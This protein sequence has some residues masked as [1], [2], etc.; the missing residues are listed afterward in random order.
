MSDFI[1]QASHG[2]GLLMAWH[3]INWAKCR[4]I[5]RSLQRRIVEAVRAGL[6]RKAKRLSHILARSFSARA[7]AVKRVTENSGK[8]TA[9]VDGEIWNTPGK[10][11]GA[12]E[13]IGNWKSYRPKPSKRIYIPKKN[14]KKRPLSIPTMEDRARQALYK[15]ALEPIAETQADSNSYGFRAKRCCAD[16]IDQCFKVFRQKNSAEWILEADIKGFF[17]H[18]SFEWM[19]NHI[20]MN[21]KILGK[22]LKCG[23]VEKKCLFPTE[24]GVPQGG[25]I[26]PVLSNMVLDGLE[27]IVTHSPMFKRKYKINFIRYAD[28][29]NVS[30]SSK[31]I[32]EEAIIPRI[33]AFLGKRGVELSREKSEIT[34]INEGFDFLGQTIRK[35][36]MDQAN[37]GKL[38]IT[39]SQ[40][41]MKAIKAKIKEICKSSG[42]LTARELIDRLNP[43]LRGWANY[44]RHA[45]C[46]ESFGKIDNYVWIRLY[47]WA[48]KRHA[49]KTGTWIYRK[50]YRSQNGWR[51]C[52]TDKKSGKSVIR[53]AQR[54]KTQP[55]IKIRGDANPFDAKWENY[56][57]ERDW[58]L[59]LKSCN[60]FQAKVFKRQQGACLVCKQRIETEEELD[61]HHLDGNH[62]NN[63]LDNVVWL[64]PN[65]HRQLHYSNRAIRHTAASPNGD[66]CNA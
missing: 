37:G 55:H 65:C 47:R 5:V 4:R 54:I 34:H 41:S 20:P 7:L 13:R 63:K 35:Y 2:D 45:I 23:F 43:V 29:F 1:S 46:N 14:G 39:P 15:Q 58:L 22:W 59:K 17:D 27:Q 25:I 40:T 12:I 51:W 48:R 62:S 32:L 36:R 21:K 11:Y 28:D 49:G 66:V 18:I 50:Y 3:G 56:F 16:A 26:S 38:Q 61:L 9:G 33:E 8:R 10:K 6:W 52:F 30:A 53:I 31:E 64:H 42:Q 60:S 57:A 19:L 44:H 24:S